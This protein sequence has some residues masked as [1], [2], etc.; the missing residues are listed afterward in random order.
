MRPFVGISFYSQM[1]C[2]SFRAPS[3]RIR[4][5]LGNKLIPSVVTKIALNSILPNLFYYGF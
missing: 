3:S 5:I 4:C 2:A 1:I